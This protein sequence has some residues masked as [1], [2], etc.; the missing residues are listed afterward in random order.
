MPSKMALVDYNKCHP[1]KHDRRVCAAALAC[2][3]ELLKQETPHEMP[4]PDPNTF[5]ING[6]VLFQT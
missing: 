5:H 6:N 3:Y 2:S 4:M 1:E